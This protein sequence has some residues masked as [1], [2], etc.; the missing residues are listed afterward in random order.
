MGPRDNP[1]HRRWFRLL[2]TTCCRFRLLH[3]GSAAPRR[4]CLLHTRSACSLASCSP[5]RATGCRSIICRSSPFHRLQEL[6]ATVPH[7]RSGGG[8]RP[9]QGWL[10]PATTETS[11]SGE[12][13]SPRQRRLAAGRLDSWVAARAHSGGG[14]SFIYMETQKGAL[15]V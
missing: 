4:I 1:V 5:L 3:A 2:F 7:A 8:A 12:G 13:A 15:W 14:S 9:R 10:A 6:T 11:G